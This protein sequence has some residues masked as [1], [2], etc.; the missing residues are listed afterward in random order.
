MNKL[1]DDPI[2]LTYRLKLKQEEDLMKQGI[3]TEPVSG[4]SY[5]TGYAYQTL[6]DWDQ[7]FEVIT[8]VYMGWPAATI[9]NGVLL[10]LDQQRDTGL[11]SRSVPSNAYHD[12]E[13][14]KPFLSQIALMV[15]QV[16]GELDW[17]LSQPYFSRLQRY[18]D[19][20]LME[21]DENHNGLSEWMSAPHTGMDNQH[22]RAGYWLDRFCEGVDLNSYLVRELQAFARLAG[23]AG[24]PDL[25][26]DYTRKSTDLASRMRLMMWD[27]QDGFF[28]DHNARA[29]ES[30]MS[31]HAGWASST[32]QS[33][34]THIRVKC[35]SSF[36][37]LWAGIATPEQARRMVYEHLFNP[38]EFW[39]PFPVAAMAKSERWY[40]RDWLPGDLGCNWRAKTWI[41]INYMIYHGLQRY[42][43]RELAGLVAHYTHALVQKSGNCEYYDAET[44]EGCGLNPFWG[45]S[46][47]AHFIPYEEQTGRDLTLIETP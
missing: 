1:N 7:Y 8:Q 29:G 30:L 47:L 16:Y 23:L 22:E 25:A 42:G 19:Y 9:K 40:S 33:P 43:Y 6:Y 36:A 13:H 46:M 10:F 34:G 28:Y 35:A 15:Y 27:E 21:M 4:R 26:A 31:R 3:V 2:L 5:F 11:I 14:C 44:G 12:P 39:S 32:N 20:W 18:L 38:R 17:I 37:A 41:P 24:K 45:W